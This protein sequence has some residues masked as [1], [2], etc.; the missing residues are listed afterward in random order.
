MTTCRLS[1][2]QSFEIWVLLCILAVQPK[3][4]HMI[5][6]GHRAKKL[7]SE[8][9]TD[10]CPN[11]GKTALELQVWQRYAHLFWI[12]AFPT[13]KL[14]LTQ[15]Q[16]CLQAVESKNFSPRIAE[17]YNTVKKQYKAPVWMYSFA[18]VVVVLIVLG[19]ILNQQQDKQNAAYAAAPQKGD[20][21][22]MKIGPG[23]YTL[24][25]VT[26]VNADS[27]IVQTHQFSTDKVTGLSKLEAKGDAGF[28]DEYV[29]YALPEIGQ[30]VKS[31]TIYGIE[32]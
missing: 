32:R 7:A 13:K 16:H 26:E 24:F 23:E 2:R 18:G 11:C 19:V 25:R 31:G 29:G 22:K 20:V 10:P 9:L 21:Y 14:G 27:V 28:S 3:E 12:P 30:M 4:I 8:A 5:I 17:T 6:F 1:G 15:C